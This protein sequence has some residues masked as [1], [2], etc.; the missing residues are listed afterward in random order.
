MVPPCSTM[1]VYFITHQ[2]SVMMM[3]LYDS[4]EIRGASSVMKPLVGFYNIDPFLRCF[5]YPWRLF[6]QKFKGTFSYLTSAT[7]KF[8]C[9]RILFFGPGSSFI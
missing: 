1:N 7:H 2:L 6:P 8:F 5:L 3:M 4:T 9:Y